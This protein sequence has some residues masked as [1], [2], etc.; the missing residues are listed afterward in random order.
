LLADPDHYLY[1]IRC[2]P[3]LIVFLTSGNI[4]EF[5][6]DLLFLFVQNGDST[7]RGSI[8]F[9]PFLY[10]WQQNDVL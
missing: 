10:L 9:N 2:I 5:W 3:Y 6:A 8:S 7:I 1:C 4:I